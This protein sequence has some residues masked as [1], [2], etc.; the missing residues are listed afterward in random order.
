MRLGPQ[1]VHNKVQAGKAL[2][3]CAYESDVKFRQ[4]ALVGAIS[5]SEFERRK[6]SLPR[7]MELVFY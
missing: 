2:L 5:F 3:I 7:D 1:E 4:A 6:V